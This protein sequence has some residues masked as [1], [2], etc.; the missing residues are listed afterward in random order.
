M[1]TDGYIS[2]DIFDK[3]EGIIL[4]ACIAHA[5]RKF[6]QALDNDPELAR[7]ALEKIQ[8]LYGIERKAR[9]HERSM[10]LNLFPG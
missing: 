3:R 5:R 1:Q 6:E 2:F 7:Y 10:M 8:A 4:L 9:E